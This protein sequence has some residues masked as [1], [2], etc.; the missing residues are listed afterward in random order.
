M[1]ISVVN[2]NKYRKLKICSPIATDLF[3]N[4]YKYSQATTD[5]QMKTLK[6]IFKF[7]ARS[8]DNVEKFRKRYLKLRGGTDYLVS[9]LISKLS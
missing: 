6:E 4:K 9:L 5:L 3:T 1:K 2:M 8:N 7:C